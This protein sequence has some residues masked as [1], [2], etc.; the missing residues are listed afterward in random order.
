MRAWGL[1]NKYTFALVAGLAI[2]I[3]YVV[4]SLRLGAKVDGAAAALLFGAAAAIVICL[5][6]AFDITR[7]TATENG[8]LHEE[9][10]SLVLALMF[11]TFFGVQSVVDSFGALRQTPQQKSVEWIT[12]TWGEAG[13]CFRPWT[14][15]V[16]DGE[17]DKETVL[18]FEVDGGSYKHRII[19]TPT[20][21]VVETDLGTYTLQP[22]GY[23]TSTEEGFEG[24]KFKRCN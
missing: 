21:N 1:L 15:S 18:F 20:P 24:K 12:H 14:F 9:R 23:M 8:K 19:G 2:A 5:S 11:P 7:H 6:L 22:D 13:K 10:F 16:E 17:E 3:F 4:V